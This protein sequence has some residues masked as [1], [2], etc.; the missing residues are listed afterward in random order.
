MTTIGSAGLLAVRFSNRFVLKTFPVNP[1]IVFREVWFGILAET[2]GAVACLDF[3]EQIIDVEFRVFLACLPGTLL[4]SL[5]IGPD[6]PEVEVLGI[7][8]L[9]RFRK[10][11]AIAPQTQYITGGLPHVVGI[12]LGWIKNKGPTH[13]VDPLYLYARGL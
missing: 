12:W 13:Y 10:L 5:A 4:P 8:S 2:P 11:R 1:G 9:E 6:V 3:L 7:R